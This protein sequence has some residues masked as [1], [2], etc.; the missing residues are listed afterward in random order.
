MSCHVQE[1]RIPR[2][3]DKTNEFQ[4][5]EG[6]VKKSNC[7]CKL[8]SHKDLTALQKLLKKKKEKDTVGPI[9]KA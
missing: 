3:T 7:N 4:G 5:V 6:T 1:H 2:A 8:G 9:E